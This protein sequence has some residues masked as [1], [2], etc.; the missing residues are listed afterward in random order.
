MAAGS[1]ATSVFIVFAKS[2]CPNSSRSALVERNAHKFKTIDKRSPT[3]LGQ[4]YK[5]ELAKQRF[6]VAFVW[7]DRR[8]SEIESE[9]RG[10]FA[11][12]SFV[13]F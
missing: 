7:I 4:L 11:P 10:Y 6:C 3:S 12:N 5:I 2:L 8:A 13:V 1:F 9:T